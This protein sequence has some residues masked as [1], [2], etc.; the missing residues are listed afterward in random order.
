MVYLRDLTVN[1]LDYLITCLEKYNQDPQ[2]E[3]LYSKVKEARSRAVLQEGSTTNWFLLP[4]NNS[5]PLRKLISLPAHLYDK[6]IREVLF[7]S[8]D[9]S[10]VDSRMMNALHRFGYTRMLE[11]M[12]LTPYDFMVL[13]NFGPRSQKRFAELLWTLKE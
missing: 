4:Q 7:E 12:E 10:N 1:D 9:G 13:R 3:S 5:T 6:T 2:Y 11:L 8:L